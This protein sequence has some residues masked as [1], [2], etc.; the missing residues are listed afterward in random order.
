MT[1]PQVNFCPPIETEL[2]LLEKKCKVKPYTHE[3][4]KYNQ[5]LN[6]RTISVDINVPAQTPDNKK[7]LLYFP[8]NYY[9][10]RLLFQDIPFN[11]N[12]R[13]K[14]MLDLYFIDRIF[15][16]G[17]GNDNYRKPSNDR[18]DRYKFL[19]SAAQGATDAGDTFTIK[20]LRK[21]F[22]FRTLV[23]QV[24]FSS[25][26]LPD[27]DPDSEQ[28][29]ATL[30]ASTVFEDMNDVINSPIK[31]N[32]RIVYE[33]IHE[34]QC[35][36]CDYETTLCDVWKIEKQWCITRS[37]ADLPNVFVQF[38]TGYFWLITANNLNESLRYLTYMNEA[39]ETKRYP[40]GTEYAPEA[41]TY[42]QGPPAVELEFLFKYRWINLG[43]GNAQ[44]LQRSFDGLSREIQDLKRK[45]DG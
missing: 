27:P 35:S 22:K 15:V 13:N 26:Q 28:Q 37:N 23:I 36:E 24:D 29:N 9:T 3:Q 31:K 7:T 10:S 40:I 43:V 14:Y 18:Q 5:L 16:F 21:S 33:K 2:S 8:T 39:D 44:A 17:Y 19:L 30:P 4:V 34:I 11:N 38:N 32:F 45:F 41:D 42:L 6:S 25:C 20:P 12:T 1:T